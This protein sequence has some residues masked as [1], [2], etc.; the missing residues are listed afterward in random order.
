[1]PL[2]LYAHYIDEV[3]ITN[4]RFERNLVVDAYSSTQQV[5]SSALIYLDSFYN[6]TLTHSTF[7]ANYVTGGLIVVKSQI[8]FP[9]YYEDPKC[10]WTRICEAYTE[11][12]SESR[13]Q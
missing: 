10:V 2:F 4:V 9:K 12:E 3:S 8:I 11:C 6:F 13:W 1:M 7:I 5:S